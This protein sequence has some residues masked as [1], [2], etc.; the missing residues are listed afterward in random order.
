MN[1][2]KVGINYNNT[3]EN[4]AIWLVLGILPEFFQEPLQTYFKTV[5]KS[6]SIFPFPNSHFFALEEI[7][8]AQ[9]IEKHIFRRLSL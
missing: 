4:Q 6:F 8:M 3:G 9:E 1:G 5:F 7:L 2:K